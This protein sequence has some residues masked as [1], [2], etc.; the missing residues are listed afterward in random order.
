MNKIKVVI[1]NKIFWVSLSENAVVTDIKKQFPLTLTLNRS[2]INEY[3]KPLPS[4]VAATA[5]GTSQVK[6]GFVYYF[7]G[8]NAFSLNFADL[9]IAPY[10]VI[11]PGRFD[12]A[13]ASQYLA[14]GPQLITVTVSEK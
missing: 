5:I 4:K 12:D 7:A 3:Y 9:N 2:G 1:Q 6:A 13:T 10:Q 14:K 11:E 8:R